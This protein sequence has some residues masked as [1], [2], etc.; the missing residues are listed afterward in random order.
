[1]LIPLADFLN[2]HTVANVRTAA[3]SEESLTFVATK[4]VLPGE[5]LCIEYAQASNLEFMI[6][7]GFRVEDNPFGGRQFDLGGEPLQAHC[8]SLILRYDVPE[9]VD[10]NTV[11]C[12][13]Q[14]RYLSFEQQFGSLTSKEQLQED[15]HIYRAVGEAC[16]QLLQMLQSPQPLSDYEVHEPSTITTA[17]VREIRTERVLLQR[18]VFEFEKRLKETAASPLLNVM[19]EDLARAAQQV[20]FAGRGAGNIQAPEVPGQAPAPPGGNTQAGG[21]TEPGLGGGDP[22]SAPPTMAAASVGVAGDVETNFG[23]PQAGGDFE[24]RKGV[25][26]VSTLLDRIQDVSS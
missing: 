16:A 4:Q 13:R 19:S 11:D 1:M 9:I 7:Y 24:V 25:V 12:H 10:N 14:A 5:E 23:D 2:H 26:D 22:R 17:L 8:P 6:R 3:I 15:R 18:C 20:Q 21:Q